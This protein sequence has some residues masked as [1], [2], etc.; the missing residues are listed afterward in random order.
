MFQQQIKLFYKKYCK[1]R[2]NSGVRSQETLR[3]PLVQN[4]YEM[5]NREK[6]YFIKIIKFDSKSLYSPDLENSLS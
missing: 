3:R 1:N 2:K 5:K 6:Q 4:A